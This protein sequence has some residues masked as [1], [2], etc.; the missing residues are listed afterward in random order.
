VGR[1]TVERSRGGSA[2]VS[3]DE[4]EFRLFYER[5]FPLAY[6]VGYRFS[7]RRDEAEDAAQEA[8]A[9]AFQRWTR[10][11]DQPW[12]VGWVLTTTLNLLRRKTRRTRDVPAPTDQRQPEADFEASLDLWHAISRLPRRQ[13]QAVTLYYLADLP[14]KHVASAMGCKEGTARAHLDRA[15][16]Q[17]ARSMDPIEGNQEA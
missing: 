10:L 15:R 13:A 14:V 3:P 1:G 7:G 11:R 17:L 5:V 2:R 12:V 4:E 6:R 9:R 16:K 8:L